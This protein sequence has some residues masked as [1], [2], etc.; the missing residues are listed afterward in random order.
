MGPRH[1]SNVRFAP[2]P[3]ACLVIKAG[4]RLVLISATGHLEDPPAAGILVEGC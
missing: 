1:V 4:R 3:D 2:E